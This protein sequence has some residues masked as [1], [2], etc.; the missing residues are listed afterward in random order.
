MVKEFLGCLAVILISGENTENW[1]GIIVKLKFL[2]FSKR[3]NNATFNVS[4]AFR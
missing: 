4:P 2:S 3:N 1:K